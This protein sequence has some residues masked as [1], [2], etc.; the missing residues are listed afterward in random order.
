M[1]SKLSLSFL[2]NMF[3]FFLLFCLDYHQIKLNENMLTYKFIFN[4]LV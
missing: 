4:L 1:F 2:V 3:F